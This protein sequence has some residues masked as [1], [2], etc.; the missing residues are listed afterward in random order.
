M[1]TV[2]V[3]VHPH[4]YAR[5]EGR[6]EFK[7]AERVS[8]RKSLLDKIAGANARAR[9][10]LS[11]LDVL[12]RFYKSQITRVQKTPGALLAIVKGVYDEP[13]EEIASLEADGVP[14]KTARRIVSF[15]RERQDRLA[16]FAKRK[17]GRR[18]LEAH[19]RPRD[20]GGWLKEELE[21][22]GVPLKTPVHVFGE[23]LETCV[24]DA[25]DSIRRAGF[26]RVK[27]VPSKSLQ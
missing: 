27:L 21:G 26:K 1:K 16:E 14:R 9:A 18:M 4:F 3:V 13:W 12:N 10:A 5:Y 15:G 25:R 22:R 17:L 6:H 23:F 20:V 8:V 2:S 11:E 24:G 7:R 19:L